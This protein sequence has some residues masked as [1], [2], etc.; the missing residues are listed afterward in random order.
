MGILLLV[1][2]GSF[3]GFQESHKLAQREKNLEAFLRFLQNAETEIRYSALPVAGVVAR[4]SGELPFLRRCAALCREGEGFTGAWERAVRESPDFTGE[5][6]ALLLRFGRGFGA[7][8]VEGQLAHCQL[9]KGLL[10][11]RLAEAREE[12]KQKARLY[13]MLGVLGGLG[14][15]LL[16]C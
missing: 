1:A 9:T 5:D 2:A 4:H 10:A 15:A 16:L 11:Q 7:T 13:Q 3:A 14:T 8:D 6:E 12:K